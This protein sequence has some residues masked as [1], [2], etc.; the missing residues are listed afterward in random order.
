MNITFAILQLVS[1]RLLSTVRLMTKRR[2][3]KI[4]CSSF[5]FSQCSSIML[6]VFKLFYTNT[7]KLD[8]C[9]GCFLK[10]KICFQL[11]EIVK[12]K[13]SPRRSEICIYLYPWL[14][15]IYTLN[16]RN[17]FLEMLHI[18]I[19]C[20]YF[21]PEHIPKSFSEMLHRLYRKL[22]SKIKDI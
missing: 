17:S 11:F 18:D 16:I 22:F 3:G 4:F 2:I 5:N 6:E 10:K 12:E 14:Q 13:V 9:Y 15:T 1:E 19:G 7:I 21:I 8:F 20:L